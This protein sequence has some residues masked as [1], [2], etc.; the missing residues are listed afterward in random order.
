MGQGCGGPAAAVTRLHL[1]GM[2]RHLES[3]QPALRVQGLLWCGVNCLL[4]RALVLVLQPL[5]GASVL[6]HVLQY[7][8]MQY[9]T[10]HTPPYL[11]VAMRPAD[12]CVLP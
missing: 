6:C 9:S 10:C 7:T 3:C 12:I 8:Y 1:S 11:D 2:P 4:Q 5:H